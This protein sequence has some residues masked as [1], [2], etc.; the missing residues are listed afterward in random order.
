[1]RFLFP[2]LLFLSLLSLL[3]LSFFAGTQN[4]ARPRIGRAPE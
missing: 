4:G 2:P 3:A 1:M